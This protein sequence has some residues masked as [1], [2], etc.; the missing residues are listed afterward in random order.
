MNSKYGVQSKRKCER[1]GTCIRI[2]G[3][4]ACTCQKKSVVEYRHVRCSTVQSGKQD[5][6]HLMISIETHTTY[7]VTS[8]FI[9]NMF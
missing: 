6:N 8:N 5:Q 1:H 2:A 7:I 4:S 3:F 9:F